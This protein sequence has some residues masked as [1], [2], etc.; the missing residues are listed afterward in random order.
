[1]TI[2]ASRA[3]NA[4]TIRARVDS[5][6]WRLVRVAPLPQDAVLSAGPFCCAPTRDGLTVHFTSWEIVPA[7]ESLHPGD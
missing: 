3:G 5:E 2:R 6:P 7:D 4:L 1:V